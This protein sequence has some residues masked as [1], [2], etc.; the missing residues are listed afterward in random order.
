MKQFLKSKNKIYFIIEHKGILSA[1]FASLTVLLGFIG[2]YDASTPY[3]FIHALIKSFQLFGLTFPEKTELN[4]G[5]ILASIAAIIT[6]GLTAVLFFFK[7]QINKKIFQNI[8]NHEHIAV[9]GLGKIARTFLDDA[10][11]NQNIIIIEKDSLY[12]ETY[13]RRGYAFKSGDAFDKE[14]LVNSLNFETM[15]YALI[16][17]GDD[18]TNIEFAKRVIKV[19]SDL[20]IQTPIKLIIHI[21]TKSLGTLFHKNFMLQNLENINIKTFSYYEECTRDLFSKY[22]I[23]G[24]SMEYIDSDK[25]LMTVLIGDGEL[26][27]RMV[28]KI[29]SLSHLPNQNRHSIYIINSESDK[30]L[31]EIKTYVNYGYDCD[32]NPDCT[33]EKFPT[34]TLK[35]L[36][37]E[38]KTKEFYENDIWKKTNLENIIV[39]FDDESKNIEV[40]NSL[41]ERT[42]LSD[43]VDKKKVPKIIM[44][45]FSELEMSEAINS[46]KSEYNN[47]YTFGNE[48][49]IVNKEH[50]L[51]E[52]IDNIAKLIHHGYGNVYEPMKSLMKNDKLSWEKIEEKWFKTS[53][54]SD[55]LSNIAQAR[56]IDIKLKSLG[57][58]KVAIKSDG[59]EDIL[60]HNRAILDAKLL[61]TQTTQEI[62]EASKEIEKFYDG[63]TYTV[64]YWPKNFEDTPLDKM[65]RMEHNRWNAYHYLEGWKYAPTKVK[66]KKEH[67]CLLP[68][69]EFDKDSIKITALYD[70]YAFLYLPNYLA[71]TGYKIIPMT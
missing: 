35:N 59:Q 58:Q 11:L 13:R 19:Y 39:C 61:Q 27:K 53:K 20:K 22:S 18:K 46:D 37:L 26:I 28:Y 1:L 29:I 67:D 17:F 30:L 65:L 54:F 48:K 56:H 15:Q 40:G 10:A 66:E 4:I 33:R 63:K 44:G 12:A 32:Y 38:Y 55:K 16:S 7:E 23:D 52:T 49:D 42:Y 31:E 47:M 8:S 24:D 51:N 43:S 3:A 62:I 14:F 34:I 60:S 69:D 64:K 5:T 36:S 70:M 50:L 68:I 25:E 45:V 9:F 21:N 2:Y 57:L 41:Q 6:V 71:E